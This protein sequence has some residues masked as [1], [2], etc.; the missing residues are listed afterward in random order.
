MEVR[1]MLSRFGLRASG[2]G[3]IVAVVVIAHR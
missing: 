2:F 3:L 1:T